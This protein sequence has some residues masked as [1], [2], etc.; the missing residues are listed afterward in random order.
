[1]TYFVE[2]L[3]QE[4]GGGSNVRRIG[5]YESLQDAIAAAEEHIDLFLTGKKRDGMTVEDLFFEYGR[6]GEVPIILTD[7]DKTMN[8]SGFNHS[9]Y[10]MRRCAEICAGT[11]GKP[12]S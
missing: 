2:G 4:P 7:D 8:V 1:M 11:P 6:F 3:T 12:A 10:A 5:E 9:R